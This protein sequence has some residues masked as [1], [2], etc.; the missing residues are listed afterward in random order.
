[1]NL[2]LPVEISNRELDGRLLCAAQMV[3]PGLKIFVGQHDFLDRVVPGASGGVYVGKHVF[4]SLFPNVSM[5]RRDLLVRHG[6]SLCHLDEEGAFFFGDETEIARQLDSRLD[7]DALPL[8]SLLCT[9][10]EFQRKHYESRS[11]SQHHHVLATGHPRFDLNLDQF[12]TYW[13]EDVRQIEAELGGFVLINTNFGLANNVFGLKDTMSTR[14]GI[15]SPNPDD[16]LRAT[17]LF[18]QQQLILASFIEAVAKLSMAFKDLRFVI[19]P[20]PSESFETYTTVFAGYPNVAVIHRGPVTPWIIAAQAV[21]HD[22]CTTGVEAYLAGT[23]VINFRP[24]EGLTVI[25]LANLVGRHVNTYE[26]LEGVLREILGGDYE[27]DKISEEWALGL[28]SNFANGALPGFSDALET[29]LDKHR[30]SSFDESILKRVT[31][32]H[33]LY[34][35][36][37]AVIRPFFREREREFRGHK[38][39][40]PGLNPEDLEKKL[41]RLSEVFHKRIRHRMFGDQLVIIE[42]N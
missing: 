3:R 4:K 24:I 9:W 41:A 17:L 40:F 11:S 33:R 23:P 8:G 13:E 16:R 34:H 19:R 21:I 12:R 10:G 38:Q 36:P 25:K 2:F 39:A 15:N 42:S 37:R 26:E 14:F 29:L 1:M 7:P 30:D 5:Q 6:L 27:N 28:F 20:H 31:I 32:N 35:A 22:G 18:A